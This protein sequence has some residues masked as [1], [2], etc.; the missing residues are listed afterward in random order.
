MQMHKP[1]QQ[2]T[3]HAEPHALNAS[4]TVA[5]LCQL[6]TTAKLNLNHKATAATSQQSSCCMDWRTQLAVH[7]SIRLVVI[8]EVYI[9]NS[10]QWWL[11]RNPSSVQ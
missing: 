9:D 7:T 5:G 3:A 2:G 1:D 8:D 10:W 11:Q 6:Q 4:A